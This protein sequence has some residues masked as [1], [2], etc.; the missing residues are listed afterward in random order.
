MTT[1]KTVVSGKYTYEVNDRWAK[2]PEGWEMPAAAVAGDSQDRIYCFNRDAGHPIV[3]F[4]R[5]GNYLSSW[6][7]GLISFAHAILL[8]QEDHVW[9]VDPLERTLEAFSLREGAWVLAAVLKDDEPVK[10]PPFEAVA[11]SLADLWA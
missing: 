4:D 3:V 8:D 11:F 2:L 7:T 5:E 9:L 10:V 1:T 6:G